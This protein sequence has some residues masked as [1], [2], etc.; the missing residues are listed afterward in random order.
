MTINNI[1]ANFRHTGI[2]PFNPNAIL[3]RIELVSDDQAQSQNGAAEDE[4]V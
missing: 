1:T 2:Y 3:D 4:S